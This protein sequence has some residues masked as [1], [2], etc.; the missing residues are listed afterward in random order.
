MEWVLFKPN[1]SWSCPRNTDL[2]CC[3]E[4]KNQGQSNQLSVREEEGRGRG[5]GGYLSIWVSCGL[6]FI[7]CFLFHL[8]I[9]F[10]VCV[11]VLAWRWLSISDR[12][13]RRL[14]TCWP[15]S[16]WA[17][18][19]AVSYHTVHFSKRQLPFLEHPT[20]GESFGNEIVKVDNDRACLT[21]PVYE[22]CVN[23]CFLPSN[24]ISGFLWK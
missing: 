17:L 10:H 16:V 7:F 19:E 2:T 5:T 21:I 4:K 22:C 24:Y 12:A 8:L 13:S 18:A 3:R 15:Q 6:P 20:N 23:V 11:A 9:G 14:T 1:S